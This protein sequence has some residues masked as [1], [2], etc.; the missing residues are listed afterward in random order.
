[1]DDLTGQQASWTIVKD[2]I[3][4]DTLIKYNFTKPGVLKLRLTVNDLYKYKQLNTINE[5]II[6][7]QN[8]E[9]NTQKL[10]I[11]NNGVAINAGKEA[12][13]ISSISNEKLSKQLNRAQQRVKRWP[14]WLSAGVVT[15]V[16]VCLSAQ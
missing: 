9:I 5:S 3:S 11:F 6:A 14:I 16:V 8:S 2:S 1:M 13:Q 10:I 7:K 12:L 15:G 4:K